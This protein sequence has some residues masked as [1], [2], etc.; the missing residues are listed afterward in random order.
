MKT[1]I[2]KNEEDLAEIALKRVQTQLLEKPESVLALACGRTMEP[3]WEKLS[4]SCIKG[5]L[6]MRD[7][8]VLCVTELVNAAP[9]KSCRHALET[10]LFSENRHQAGKLL[11]PGSDGSGSI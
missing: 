11:F 4:L 6:S 9:D 5:E 8:R 7:A 1:E 10:G 3:L 2:C